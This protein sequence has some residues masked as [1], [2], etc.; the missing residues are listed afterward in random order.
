MSSLNAGLPYSGVSHNYW[1]HL[2]HHQR[3]IRS[4]QISIVLKKT[5]C[6]EIK[7]FPRSYSGC[8]DKCSAVLSFYISFSL[9]DSFQQ[10]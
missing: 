8:K 2:G 10:L 4:P 3:R 5:K 7:A 9:E 1:M 6:G